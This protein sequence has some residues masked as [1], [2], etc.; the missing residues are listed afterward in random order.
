MK[1]G[2]SSLMGKVDESINKGK[3]YSLKIILRGERFTQTDQASD[4]LLNARPTNFNMT[5][6][7]AQVFEF[8]T[9]T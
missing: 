1:E 4:S 3:G 7:L 6:F 8:Q 5:S 9:S 2:K